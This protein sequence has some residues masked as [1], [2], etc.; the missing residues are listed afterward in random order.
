MELIPGTPRLLLDGAHNPSG[1]AA[2]SEELHDFNYERLLLVTG[3]MY[4][5]DVATMLPPLAR[6]AAKCFCVAPAIERALSDNELADMLKGMGV[7]AVACGSVAEGLEAAGNEAR[8]DDLILV[9]GSLFTV[10]ETK[11]WLTGNTFR[12]I[13]G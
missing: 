11:A 6:C 8:P 5:K 2:L 12:G 1:V 3:V 9:T 10:G 13:R 4:D 7:E